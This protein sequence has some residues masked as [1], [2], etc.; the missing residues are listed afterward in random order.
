MY[1]LLALFADVNILHTD[2]FFL[3]LYMCVCNICTWLNPVATTLDFFLCNFSVAT[4]TTVFFLCSP[5]WR[6]FWFHFFQLVEREKKY[7]MKLLIFFELSRLS[8]QF[9]FFFAQFTTE[10]CN[11]PKC[12]N[13]NFFRVEY[14][15]FF[16]ISFL[17]HTNYSS[18]FINSV[19]WW[20]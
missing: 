2:H 19:D 16:C 1:W 9:H 4:S 7:D 17:L 15:Y 10:T 18:R 11:Y 12:T 6:F 3:Y 13:N 14:M 20:Y 5:P 8:L